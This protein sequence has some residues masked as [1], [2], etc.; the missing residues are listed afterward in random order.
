MARCVFCEEGTA[1]REHVIPS[2][3]D[4]P[5]KR[6]RPLAPGRLRIGLTHRYTPPSDSGDSVR[7]WSAPG[8]DLVTKEVC[9]ICNNE[10]LSDLET[11]IRAAVGDMVVGRPV[12]LQSADQVS[13]AAWCY[14][15]ILLIQLVRPGKFS[16]IPRRRYAEFY[17]LRRPPSDA[18]VWLGVVSQ[19]SSVLH[20]VTMR[21]DM[22]T[23]SARSPG[24]FAA[25]SIGN[26][27]ILCGGRCSVSN[28]PFRV[29]ARAAG[30]ALLALWPASVRSMSWPP[31]TA[32]EDLSAK[33]LVN[34]I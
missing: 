8:P 17:R 33:A 34:L 16:L 26:L 3:L 11:T 5:I 27:L 18:R 23:L 13:V 24:Y 10:M 22:T 19:G 32:I 12:E 30:T 2:W 1:S 7:E 14:K 21:V 6:S 15:T 4:V 28:A 31:P 29:E 9:E 20:E 25:L